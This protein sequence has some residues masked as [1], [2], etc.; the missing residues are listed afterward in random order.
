MV[1]PDGVVLGNSRSDISG[2]DMNRK[3]RE[4]SKNPLLNYLKKKGK[5]TII[6]ADLHA[7]S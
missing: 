2:N 3:W 6:F 4:N 1:N 5:R 7:H